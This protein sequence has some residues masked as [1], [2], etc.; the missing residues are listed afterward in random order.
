MNKRILIVDD[1]E[2]IALTLKDLF[3]SR[4]YEVLVA[5]RGKEAIEY[6]N[7]KR[8]DLI[9]LDIEMPGINGVEVLKEV[10]KKH[11]GIK[12]VVLTG[13]LEAYK[14]EIERIGCN[15]F[16]NKP[17]S[18]KT[19]IQV[20]DSA[21]TE[22]VDYKKDFA[23]LIKD[24]GILAKA[25][26]LFVEPNE[27]MYSSKLAYFRDPKRC[28][29]EYEFTASFTKGQILNKLGD[30]RPDIVLSN[31]DMFR[32][33]KLGDVFFDSPNAPKDVILYGLSASK[34]ATRTKDLAFIGGLF[35]PITAA[36]TPKEMDKLGDIVRSTA[37]GHG[38]YI[39]V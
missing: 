35:D 19:L 28:R 10:K 22:Q 39:R 17:F 27:I 5:F 33:Y 4:G 38:L 36:V 31:I 29:G 25:R 15:A 1:E 12:T 8:L 13:F 6:L 2:S 32:L 18:I 16:L 3:V 37:I 20:L 30:F 23:G 11:P 7:E 26:L 24:S 21:L 14:D 34:D 9:L